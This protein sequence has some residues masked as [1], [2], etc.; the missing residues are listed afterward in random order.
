MRIQ[1]PGKL[2]VCAAAVALVV[3]CTGRATELLRTVTQSV[4]PP[5]AVADGVIAFSSDLGENIDVWS[6][7][8]D[9]RDLL[10]LTDSSGADQSSA[11]SPDGRRI[12]FRSDRDGNDEIYVMDADG[13]NQR[14]LTRDPHSDYSP[15]WSPDG[16]W[17]AFASDRDAGSPGYANDIWLIRPDGTGAHRITH[18][19]GID[20]YPVWSPDSTRVAFNCS[21][22]RILPQGVGDFEVCVVAADGG[23]VRRLTNG[24]GSSSVGGWAPDGTIL[25]TSSREDRPY[26]VSSSG[27]LFAMRE[28]G[29]AVRQLTMGPDLDTDPTWSPDW[30]V[31]LFASDRGN[32]DG[33]TDLWVM[34]PD[35]TGVSR[36]WGRKGEEQEPAWHR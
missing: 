30:K 35:G 9:G 32:E 31:I 22:G 17:I 8:T 23:Q 20:E 11:W 26:S 7:R 12:A 25:F 2:V 29:S 10:R 14:N 15:A 36:L 16:R 19:V 1:K 21:G 13:S 4:P 28:D 5:F 3:S 33:S 34:R 27:D 18:H 6:I 24:A